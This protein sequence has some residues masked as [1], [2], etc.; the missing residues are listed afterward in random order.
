IESL[1]K[2]GLVSADW[3]KEFPNQAAPY[4]T[5]TVFLV[6]KGNPKKIKDWN[7]LI[8]PGYAVIVPNPKTSGNGRYTYLAAWGYALDK[9]KG[10][11]AKA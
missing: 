11:E 9:S 7:D 6:R 4:T 2:A 5:T 10:D 8:K 3:R 1:V